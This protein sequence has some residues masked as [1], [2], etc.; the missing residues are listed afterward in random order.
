MTYL[1]SKPQQ[2]LTDGKDRI[3]HCFKI[4]AGDC[5]PSNTCCNMVVKKLEF[6]ARKYSKRL[7]GPAADACFLTSREMLPSQ[8]SPQMQ[9]R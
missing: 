9:Q 3:Q 6:F 8:C 1:N 2:T 5:D 4:T 7:V